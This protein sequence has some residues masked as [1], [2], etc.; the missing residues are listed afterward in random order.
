MVLMRA[1]P[2]AGWVAVKLV[3]G[4][5]AENWIDGMTGLAAVCWA[6]ELTVTWDDLRDS[7]MT[8]KMIGSIVGRWVNGMAVTRVGSRSG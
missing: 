5:M 4:S 2:R 3:V 7:W 1:D 8:V 6:D